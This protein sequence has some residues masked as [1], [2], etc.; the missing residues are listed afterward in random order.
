MEYLNSSPYKGWAGSE[1]RRDEEK[2]RDELNLTLGRTKIRL[3][4]LIFG[5]VFTLF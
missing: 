4:Q 2:M 3:T 1:S 5:P